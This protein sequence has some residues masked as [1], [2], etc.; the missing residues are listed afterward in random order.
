MD[1]GLQP[2]LCSLRSLPRLLRLFLWQTFYA[3]NA[4]FFWCCNVP[5]PNFSYYCSWQTGAEKRAGAK[6]N[7]NNMPP[8]VLTV[9]LPEIWPNPLP[10]LV[11]GHWFATLSM[12][13]TIIATT[14]QIVSLA[15]VLRSECC[16]FLVL[17]CAGTKLL[18][19]LQLANRGRKKGRREDE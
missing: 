5:A 9:N 4:A 3:V 16:F 14:S 10:P 15:D 18:L 1:T 6:M 11:F 2:Y 8:H 13:L 17:Q 19:L 7:R 12:Q